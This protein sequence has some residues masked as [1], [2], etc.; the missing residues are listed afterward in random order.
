M[1]AAPI[2]KGA[3]LPLPV[4]PPAHLRDKWH[5][6]DFSPWHKA[7]ASQIRDIFAPLG[8]VSMCIWLI[9]FLY[10][11]IGLGTLGAYRCNEVF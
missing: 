8:S 3:E 10:A 1:S 6:E 2:A 7:V 4:Q 9:I 11:G 5:N